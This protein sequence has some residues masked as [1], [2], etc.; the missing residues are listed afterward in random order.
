MTNGPDDPS[1]GLSLALLGYALQDDDPEGA[2]YFLRPGRALLEQ[3]ADPA[4][5]AN[6]YND[7]AEMADRGGR[8][9][10]AIE[11]R[12]LA[13]DVRPVAGAS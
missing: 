5:L 7:L 13:N 12:R 10:E 6:L 9:E 11:A 3:E 2:L 8:V 4:D 1:T